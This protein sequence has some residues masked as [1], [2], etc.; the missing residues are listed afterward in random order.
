[1]LV[2]TGGCVGASGLE[3]VLVLVGT[4]GCV[5]ASELEAVL[6]LVDWRLCRC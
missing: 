5:G 6:V 3:A 4:G 1:M 2:G